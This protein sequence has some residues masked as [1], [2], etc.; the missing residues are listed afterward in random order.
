MLWRNELKKCIQSV[1]MFISH[2]FLCL[3]VFTVEPEAAHERRFLQHH[4]RWK[5]KMACE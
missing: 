4:P 5:W 1:Y 3:Y 2:A